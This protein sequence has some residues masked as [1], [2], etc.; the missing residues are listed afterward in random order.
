MFYLEKHYSQYL[1]VHNYIKYS[2]LFLNS[3]TDWVFAVT[4]Q[5]IFAIFLCKMLTK[6]AAVVICH[7]NKQ[8]TSP[9]YYVVKHNMLPLFYVV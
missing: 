1:I 8:K 4:A 7:L 2:T 5:V 9:L 3:Q 6:N